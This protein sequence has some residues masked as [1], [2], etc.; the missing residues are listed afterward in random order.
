[1]TSTLK[2]SDTPASKE[3]WEEFYEEG[4]GVNQ[5]EWYNVD[6]DVLKK[7]V[8]E[9]HSIIREGSRCLQVG[10]IE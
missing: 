2:E 5:Y 10:T 8:L 1:M 3:Y 6:I 4:P 9:D 7:Q